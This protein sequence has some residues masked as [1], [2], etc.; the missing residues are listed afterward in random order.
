LEALNF[1]VEL[2]ELDRGVDQ[3]S[4][5]MGLALVAGEIESFLKEKFAYHGSE[6]GPVLADGFGEIFGSGGGGFEFGGSLEAADHA[7]DATEGIAVSFDAET[8]G[9]RCGYEV[10]DVRDGIFE[11]PLEKLSALFLG[12]AGEERTGAE[13]DLFRCLDFFVFR[14]LFRSRKIFRSRYR[15]DK[16]GA[17]GRWLRIYIVGRGGTRPY[18]LGRGGTH[19]YHLG[20]GGTRPYG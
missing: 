16:R 12:E 9:R 1:E 14:I 18:W 17:W 6:L 5:F 20:R 4:E 19:P 10:Q 8:V 11:Q 13:V 3:V 15:R 2:A 7:F